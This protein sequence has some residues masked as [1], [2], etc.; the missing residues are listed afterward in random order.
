[1]GLVKFGATSY[2]AN[3][4]TGITQAC[5]SNDLVPSERASVIRIK[6]RVGKTSASDLLRFEYGANACV[7]IRVASVKRFPRSTP[8]LKWHQ[9][10]T[11]SKRVDAGCL[12]VAV[13][14]VP[15]AVSVVLDNVTVRLR[16]NS[17]R[18]PAVA[19]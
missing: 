3:D 18:T 12:E 4:S 10:C 13:L 15:G 17:I 5:D 8:T 11:E 6:W 2:P 1:M 9:I 16:V 19:Q 7:A 14:S